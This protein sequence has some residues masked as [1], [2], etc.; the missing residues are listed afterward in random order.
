MYMSNYNTVSPYIF[1]L[2]KGSCCFAATNGTTIQEISNSKNF[3]TATVA[4]IRYI[5]DELYIHE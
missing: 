4:K 3:Y 5:I 1:R 2:S